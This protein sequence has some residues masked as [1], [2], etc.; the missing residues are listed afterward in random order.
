MTS[1]R[2]AAAATPPDGRRER[3][4]RSRD[5]V[6]DA[7]LS[8]YD[9]GH[10]RP[11]VALIAE[12]AGVSQSSVFRHFQDL[13]GLVRVA[14]DHQWDR[15]RHLF[16]PPASDG[17]LDDRIE[18]LV[19]HRL[20]LYEAAGPTLRSAR[21]LAPESAAIRAAFAYRRQVLRQQVADHF[22]A[23]LADLPAATRSLTLDALDVA[24]GFEQIEA[25]RIDRD[26]SPRRTAAVMALTVAALLTT[27]VER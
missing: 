6:V 27:A 25:L 12:R 9:E 4:A 13:D 21:L 18:R 22:A 16:E 3:S 1:P 2:G 24:T 23:E 19:A 17:D 8:L 20:A 26:T 15:L 11:G 7:L 14:I 10:L 5:A